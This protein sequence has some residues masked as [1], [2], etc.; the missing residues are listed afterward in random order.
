MLR[1]ALAAVGLQFEIHARD[2]PG[3]PDLVFRDERLCVFCDGDF[4]HGRDWRARETRLRQGANSAYW[5]SKIA[6]NR[7]RD[8]AQT[9]DLRQAGWSVR[10]FWETDILKSPDAAVR[11]LL[12]ELNHPPRAGKVKEAAAAK[13][14]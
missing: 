7:A 6:R 4:W 8:R 9:R 3:R 11:R 10:R 1:D 5:L 2:L 13:S 14:E 12:R